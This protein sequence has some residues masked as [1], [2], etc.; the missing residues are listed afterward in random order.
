MKKLKAILWR[1]WDL[2]RSGGLPPYRY[3]AASGQEYL[4]TYRLKRAVE[5]TTRRNACGRYT[6]IGAGGE[7]LTFSRSVSGR[8]RADLYDVDLAKRLVKKS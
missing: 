5:K 2:L 7:S 1:V 4:R 3:L 8:L 6:V